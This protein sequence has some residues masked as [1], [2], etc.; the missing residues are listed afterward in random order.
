[1]PVQFEDFNL[2][3]SS[4]VMKVDESNESIGFSE[5]E[6]NAKVGK[7]GKILTIVERRLKRGPKH[8]KESQFVKWRPGAKMK[9][10]FFVQGL[11][12][13]SG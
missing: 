1:M 6:Q 11:V 2:E 10:F 3:S 9:L 12:T 7:Q 5:G 13:Q 8:S 4:E